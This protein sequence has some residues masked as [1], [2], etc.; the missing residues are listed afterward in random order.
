MKHLL[1]FNKFSKFSRI[2]EQQQDLERRKIY[3][4]YFQIRT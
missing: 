4:L 3:L 1:I 2:R